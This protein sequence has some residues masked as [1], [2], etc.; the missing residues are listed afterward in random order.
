M[1]LMIQEIDLCYIVWKDAV[2]QTSYIQYQVSLFIISIALSHMYIFSFQYLFY[3]FVFCSS[4]ITEL[5]TLFK[6]LI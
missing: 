1:L 5:Y 2:V 3:M 6:L 4:F